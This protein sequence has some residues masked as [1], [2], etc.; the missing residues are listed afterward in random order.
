MKTAAMV[1]GQGSFRYRPVPGWG[2]LD[3]GT[4]V[5]NCNAIV[6][7]RAGHIIVLTDHTANNVI[8]YDRTGRLVDKWGTDLPGA[9]GMSIVTEGD[10]EVLYLTCTLTNRVRKTTLDGEVLQEWGWPEFTGKYDQANDYM[11]AWTLHHP[12]GEF[13]VL[14]GYGRD[15]ILHYGANGVFK[16][17]FGGGEGG[18]GHWGPHGGVVDASDPTNPHLLIAMC[19]QQH[20]LRL[21][22]TGEKLLRVDM[23]GGNPRM[24]HR[25]AGHWY[26]PHIGD[27]WP[28]DFDS[29]GFVSVLDDELRVVGNIGGTPPL[30]DNAGV[31]QPMKHQED[32]FIHPHDVVVDAHDDSLYV[33]QASSGTIYPL[34]LERV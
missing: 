20:L 29:R 4:P 32:F 34:K 12:N 15:Y 11:P 8:V 13:F 16:R 31:L 18:I 1:M 26:C 7:D 28:T 27:N 6:M 23:P 2:V 17:I 10:R 22:T 30:Y 21:S 14:D 33:A 3:A 5:K 9:H 19:D 24:F 25:H